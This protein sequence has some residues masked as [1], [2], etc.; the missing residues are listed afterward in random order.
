VTAFLV[1]VCALLG[2]VIGSFLNVGIYRVPRGGSVVRP[3]S[4]CPGCG[5]QVRP[6]DEIPLVSWLL[7]KGKCRDCGVPIS[8]RYFVVELLTGVLFAAIAGRFG[9]SAELPAYLYLAAISV[10]LALIDLDVRRLP[11]SL[12]LPSYLV[13]AVLLAVAALVGHDAGPLLRAFAGMAVLYVAFFLLAFAYPGG[14]GFGDVKLAGVLGL[15]LGWLG[16]G[17]VVV[18][19][20]AGF[21]LGGLVGIGLILFGSAG[22]KSK[23]PFGPFMVTGALVAVF[24]GQ[25]VASG[26]LSVTVH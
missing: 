12:T 3:R 16:W 26:Y 8:A 21:V 2:L 23:V 14:M 18:G 11:N 20:F 1:V 22:R 13:G 19:A 17:S 5:E 10:A 25:T 9:W 4:H 15:Y 24:I 6:R 7:L